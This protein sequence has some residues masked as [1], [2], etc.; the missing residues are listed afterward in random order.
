MTN[1]NKRVESIFCTIF[2]FVITWANF[3][4]LCLSVLFSPSPPSSSRSESTMCWFLG[5][6]FQALF[7]YIAEGMTFVCHWE[8]CGE[9]SI[10]VP[11]CFVEVRTK[12]WLRIDGDWEVA[13]DLLHGMMRM[14]HRPDGR[15][16]GSVARS[17][18]RKATPDVVTK[19]GFGDFLFCTPM[20]KEFQVLQSTIYYW[21]MNFISELYSPHWLYNLLINLW[22][23]NDSSPRLLNLLRCSKCGG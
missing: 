16:L 6:Y 19:N 21:H 22:L 7:D 15:I 9:A 10:R 20:V 14:S 3:P 11:S 13:L 12:T 18:R 23:T 8:C 5:A 2:T 17:L 1:E 4:S